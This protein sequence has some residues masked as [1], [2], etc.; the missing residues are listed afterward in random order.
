MLEIGGCPSWPPPGY[1]YARD[2]FIQS[3][4]TKGKSPQYSRSNLHI[5]DWFK[6]NWQCR[7]T[8]VWC[9]HRHCCLYIAAIALFLVSL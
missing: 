4:S 6:Y 8:A 9:C 5:R 2:H 7:P 1:A 3:C